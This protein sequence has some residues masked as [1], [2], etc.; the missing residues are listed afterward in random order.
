MFIYIVGDGDN[1]V[2]EALL[3]RF[4]ADN[5][6]NYRFIDRALPNV[7]QGP[8]WELY[9]ADSR[10][11][12][13]MTFAIDQI[14][15]NRRHLPNVY[16]YHE[17]HPNEIPELNEEDPVPPSQTELDHK[18]ENFAE[19]DYYKFDEIPEQGESESTEI[20]SISDE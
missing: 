14:A 18:L 1:D 6:C 13:F 15:E 10:V 5:G 19:Y 11:K 9:D 8:D 20:Y 3:D 7:L 17:L 2:K 4:L 12:C 16:Q